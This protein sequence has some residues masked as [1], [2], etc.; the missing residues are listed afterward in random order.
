MR[1]DTLKM[2]E[3]IAPESKKTLQELGQ[4]GQMNAQLRSLKQQHQVQESNM[5]SVVD[6]F[7]IVL[8]KVSHLSD[9]E[10]EALTDEQVNEIYTNHEGEEIKLNVKK[11][12][13]PEQ[14]IAFK[15][16]FIS[17]IR[18]T[19][20]VHKEIDE[21]SEQ[22]QK[23]IAEINAETRDIYNSTQGNIATYVRGLLQKEY[24][25]IDDET[26]KESI[27]LILD[28]FDDANH[29]TRVKAAFEG[30]NMVNTI[31]DFLRNYEQIATKFH[32]NCKTVGIAVDL[33]SFTNFE[34]RFL[35]EKYHKYPNLFIFLIVKWFAKKKDLNKVDGVF[36][37]Q[38]ASELRQL[39]LNIGNPEITE[40]E[41]VRFDNLKNAARSLLDL[42]YG[43]Q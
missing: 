5:R 34:A 2:L 43:K 21:A 32:K 29:L 17:F 14:L 26:R 20:K 4:I 35:E 13:T 6:E 28:A 25:S 15:K 27:K 11:N 31:N 1:T 19:A 18:N 7:D 40:D 30:L 39:Y 38:L 42:V 12:I 16:D 24:D 33:S 36:L 10:V 41:K 23:D 8:E 22:L 9:L 37:T 3:G